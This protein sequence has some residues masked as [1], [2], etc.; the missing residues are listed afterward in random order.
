MPADR[1]T[2]SLEL[3]ARRVLPA[4]PEAQFLGMPPPA[5]PGSVTAAR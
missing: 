5:E 3:A 2:A 4:R 1:S